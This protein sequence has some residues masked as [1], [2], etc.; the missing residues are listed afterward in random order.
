VTR[1]PSKSRGSR[2]ATSEPISVL[3]E[4]F[5]GDTN[6]YGTAFGGKILALM[7]RAAGLAA[8][9]LA[10]Q[11]FVT[12]SLDALEFAAPVRQGEIAEVE[13]RVVYTSS[14]TCA[15]HVRVFAIDKRAWDRRQCCTGTVFMVAVGP[16]GRPLSIPQLVPATDEAKREWDDARRIHEAMLIRRARRDRDTI[17]PPGGRRKKERT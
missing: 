10:H 17:R 12:A 11:H 9:R 1:S 5:P 4:I 7:D 16:D 15:A 6:P 3:E 14:H 8:S 2:S 13:A